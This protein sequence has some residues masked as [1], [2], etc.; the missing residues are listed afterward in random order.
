M[1]PLV[2][3]GVADEYQPHTRGRAAWPPIGMLPP[4]QK[5]LGT[6]LGSLCLVIFLF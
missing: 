3:L 5:V 4:L 2:S 1:V 6:W